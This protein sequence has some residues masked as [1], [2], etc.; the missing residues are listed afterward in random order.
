[1]ISVNNAVIFKLRR[2]FRAK[3]FLGFEISFCPLYSNHK[4]KNCMAVNGRG[5]RTW[6]L[7]GWVFGAV[8]PSWA[9]ATKERSREPSC[10]MLCWLL[11]SR[12]EE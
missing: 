7:G 4:S 12:N 6:P 5:S 8:R 3:V 2:I 9:G 1:M 11:S 10:Y